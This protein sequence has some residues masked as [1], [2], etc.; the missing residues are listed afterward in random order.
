MQIVF[1][2]QADFLNKYSNF[3]TNFGSTKFTRMYK[4]VIIN[5]GIVNSILS[6]SGLVPLS[7][8]SYAAYLVH[9]IMM[10]IYVFS[11]RN[12]VYLAD[13]DVVST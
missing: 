3:I 8:M 11:K 1:K 13:F 12:L 10:M 2:F 5:L 6:W 4:E 9:P 7:R